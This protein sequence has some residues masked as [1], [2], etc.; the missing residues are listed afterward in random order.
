M[1]LISYLEIVLTESD[2]HVKEISHYRLQFILKKRFGVGYTL[3]TIQ[4]TFQGSGWTLTSG[5]GRG[6]VYLH[7]IPEDIQVTENRTQR[8]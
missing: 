7:R 5:W 3:K 2:H 1:D 6:K 8:E 4:K